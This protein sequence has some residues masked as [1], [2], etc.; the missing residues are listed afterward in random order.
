MTMDEDRAGMAVEY[1]LGTLDADERAQA[2]ALLL[3]DPEFA[4]EVQRWERRLGELNALVAPVEPPAPP[5]FS[6]MT[7]WPSMSEKRCANRRPT[8]STGPP[9][10]NGTTIVT[11][12]VGQVCA[13]A[14][15]ADI[16]HST[17]AMIDLSMAP[18]QIARS[19]E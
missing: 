10:G 18:S 9:A 13:K 6:M 15:P 2:D 19:Y 1:A 11:G 4:A 3:V 14:A 16:E 7:C 17:S 5:T 8:R 12:R